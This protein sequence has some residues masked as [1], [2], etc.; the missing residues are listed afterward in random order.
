MGCKEKTEIDY[1]YLFSLVEKWTTIKLVTIIANVQGWELHHMDVKSHLLKWEDKTR[2]L[3]VVNPW[4]C[5]IRTRTSLQ[6]Q[7]NLV[8]TQASSKSLVRK[9]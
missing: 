1:K 6:V 4:I 3:F 2:S 9:N 8:W 5:H 7:Q